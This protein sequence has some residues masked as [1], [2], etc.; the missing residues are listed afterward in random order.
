M[1]SQRNIF[2]IGCLLLAVVSC[3]EAP[4]IPGEDTVCI[5]AEIGK[6]ESRTSMSGS[7]A[8]F[9]AGDQIGVFETLTSRANAPYSYNGTAWSSTAPIYWRNGTSA[10]NFYAY[11][12]YNATSSG[13]KV[14][15][16]VLSTQTISN[17]VS[18][19]SDMLVASRLNQARTSGVGLTFRHAFALIQFNVKLSSLPLNINTLTRVT[20]RG[21]NTSGGAAPYGMVNTSGV[22]SQVG[23]DLTTGTVTAASNDAQSYAQ[24]FFSAISGVTLT[25]AAITLYA[26]V[27][28]GTYTNP[29]PAVSFR[30]TILIATYN[31]EFAS[32]TNTTL[33]AGK[34]YIYNVSIGLLTR[35]APPT[36]ELAAVVP[37]DDY[38][39]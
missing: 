5:H 31:T 1:V 26:F 29:V 23:Y 35:G 16:P 32:F 33:E 10:H 15:M 20:I 30:I 17:A 22:P 7:T 9:T 19:A 11:Y 28:P 8:S 25:T 27:L 21:G 3:S 34:K 4:P 13:T 36:A 14:A 39:E 12:P 37:I 18:P 6:E 38:S 2:A 24:T